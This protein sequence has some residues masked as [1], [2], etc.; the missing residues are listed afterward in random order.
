MTQIIR[1]G[2]LSTGLIA[3]K[4]AEG[5]QAVP[6][7]Q[8]IAVGSRS[9]ESAD[10]FGERFSIPKR[11]ASYEALVNDPDVDVIYIGTPHNFH[12]ENM[13]LCL[14]AG[15]H[16]LC[17]KPFT[18]NAPEAAEVIALAR[19]KGL[20]LMEA[21]W[22]RY[23]PAMV[24]L[25][26]LLAEKAIGDV[27]LV[28]ADFGY[29]MGEILPEHRIF[30]PKFGG[31]AL[32]DVGIYP[33]SL[34]SMIYGKQ[35]ERIASL[36]HL[37][38]T[39]VDELSVMT[40]AYGKNQSAIAT[41]AIQ[42]DTQHEAWICG[43]K[44]RIHIPHFW[45]ATGLTLYKNG[46]EAQPISMPINGNGYNYQAQEVGECIRAGKPESAIM[47]LDESLAIMQTMDTIRAE[48]DLKYPME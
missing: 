21:M 20:F 32:L 10:E 45:R 47:P 29:R 38:E 35:P 39:G 41:T 30:N 34:I 4:F 18:V 13:L 37:G 8:L 2:I 11:H 28:Q 12:Q 16:V 5:L 36:T 17:E 6:D 23:F 14:N 3:K 40:F 24:K 9:Q 15:K 43:T 25:R 22:S 33:I 7:A 31:G 19:E 44:G 27:M 1:W 42:V 46:E 48:W 26:E